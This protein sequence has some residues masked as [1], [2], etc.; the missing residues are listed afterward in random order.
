MTERTVINVNVY[1]LAI[2]DLARYQDRLCE[3]QKGF[4]RELLSSIFANIVSIHRLLYRLRNLVENGEAELMKQPI[5]N[6]KFSDIISV[7]EGES[8]TVCEI[9]ILYLVSQCYCSMLMMK[10]IALEIACRIWIYIQKQTSCGGCGKDHS[11][12]SRCSKVFILLKYFFCKK[13]PK[14]VSVLLLNAAKLLDFIRAHTPLQI[15]D[16]ENL[17]NYHL[18]RKTLYEIKWYNYLIN[19]G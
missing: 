3:N 19:N 14:L 11:V 1:K 12:Y 9:V 13:M 15:E 10:C 18:R 7:E 5:L 6:I 8:G 17:Y 16:L 2:S 4:S